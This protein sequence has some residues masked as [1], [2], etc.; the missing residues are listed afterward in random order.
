V[1]LGFP[2]VQFD[3]IL[4]FEMLNKV[5]KGNG[6]TMTDHNKPS[7]QVRETNRRQ[8]TRSAGREGDMFRPGFK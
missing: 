5:T 1:E 6:K 8:N 3:G 7:K 2:A 4:V